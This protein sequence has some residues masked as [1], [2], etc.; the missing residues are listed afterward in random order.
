VARPA[1]P[2]PS[3]PEPARV[4]AIPEPE[5]SE[6][7]LEVTTLGEPDELGGPPPPVVPALRKGAKASLRRKGAR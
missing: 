4:E 1:P 2:P 7:E 5:P 6:S 3:R